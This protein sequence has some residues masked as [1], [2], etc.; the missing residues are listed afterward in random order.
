MPL[1]DNLSLRVLDMLGLQRQPPD[2]PYL[3]ALLAAYVR[4]VPWESAF[5]IA[6][7]G[8]CQQ[9]SDCARWPDDFWSD[10]I[11]RGGGGTCF[12]SNYA[13]FAL[14]QTLGYEGYL[15][16]NDIHEKVGCHTAIVL[17]LDGERWL[18]DVGMPLHVPIPLADMPTE[19]T[20]LLHTYIATPEGEDRYA[21]TRTQHPWPYAFTLVDKP[22]DDATYR[23]AVE[24]DYGP[25]GY[26]LDRVVINK[27]INDQLWRYNSAEP[28]A[29]IQQ[30]IGSERHDW[31]IDG[32]AA[33][34]L[35]AHFDIDQDTVQAA[36]D[37]L[38]RRD[39][40]AS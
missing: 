40:A 5:R 6:K 14:L 4:R 39:E 3:D 20:S 15:T 1:D 37:A 17:L 28:P 11:E 9:L 7:R 35:A 2:L 31:P 30:F 23:A 18:V 34:R 12:E 22:V 33:E 26:F 27:V 13:F 21:L 25:N 16:I 32:S 38:Q 10:A 29:Q 36:F 24:A 19:R 8:R